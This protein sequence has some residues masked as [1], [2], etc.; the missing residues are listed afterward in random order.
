MQTSS[1]ARRLVCAGIQF[2]D[3][4]KERQDSVLSGFLKI[5]AGSSLI[6]AFRLL[7]FP[8]GYT[9][10]LLHFANATW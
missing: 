10:V 9:S 4:G 3:P 7:T 2:A 6:C 1:Q 5:P 8:R